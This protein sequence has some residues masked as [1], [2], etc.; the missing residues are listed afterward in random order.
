M[1]V[2]SKTAAA[3]AAYILCCQ[4]LA[5]ASPVRRAG[6]SRVQKRETIK[7]VYEIQTL[8]G[9]TF[10]IN[11]VPNERFSGQYKGR[12]AMAMAKAYSKYGTPIPDDLLS[13]IEEILEELGLLGNNGTGSSGSDTDDDSQG[14]CSLF[15]PCVSRYYRCL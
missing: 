9:M 8:G 3:V 15:R 2:T 11:Q 7:S 10:K 13:T 4:D 12:G 1:K 6:A 14:A 5:L